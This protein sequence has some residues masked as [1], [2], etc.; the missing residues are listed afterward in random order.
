MFGKSDKKDNIEMITGNPKKAILKLSIPMMFTLLISIL[1]NVVDSI[2]VVGLGPE[3]LVAMGL[4]TPLYMVIISIGNGIGAGA[5]SLIS[6]YIGAEKYTQ[7]IV[8]YSLFCYTRSYYI[9]IFETSVN[10]IRCRNIF[11][12]WNGL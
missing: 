8:I 6:R 4:I 3:P 7:A 2:W 12:I 1:Y 9:N 10:I 5:N 11:E